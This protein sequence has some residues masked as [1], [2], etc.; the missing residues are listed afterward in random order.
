MAS[1]VMIDPYT[2]DSSPPHETESGGKKTWEELRRSVNETMKSLIMLGSSPPTSFTFRMV[3]EGAVVGGN[4]WLGRL[5]FLGTPEKAREN[6]LLYADLVEEEG[7]E[8]ELGKPVLAWTNLLDILQPSWSSGQLSRE[9]Q[10]ML[11]RKRM[12]SYGITSYDCAGA[13]GRFVF[14]ANSCLYM[15]EDRDLTC[16]LPSSIP[17]LPKLIETSCAG[18]RL[19]PKICPVCADI[20]AFVHNNDIWVTSLNTFQE[21]QLTFTQ[22]DPD[23]SRLE[24]NPLTAGVPSFVMSEEFD[25]YTGYWWQ[26]VADQSSAGE[27]QTLRVLYEEVDEG[28]VEILRIFA[29]SSQ[30]SD[31]VDEYRYPRAG[32]ANASSVLKI[33]EFQVNSFGPVVGSRQERHLVEPLTTHC[34]WAEYLVR[35]GWTPDGKYVYAQVLDRSQQHLRLLLIPVDCFVPVM[36]GD[37]DMLSLDLTTYPP[38]Q[39]IYEESNSIWINVHDILHFFPQTF[40]NEIS[41]VWASQKSGYRHLYHV[42]SSVSSSG[43]P[44]TLPEGEGTVPVPSCGQGQMLEEK[45]LTSGEWDVVG[46]QVWVDEKRAIV[47]FTGLKDTP[48]EMHLYAVSY[49][50]PS[51]IV[52]LTETGYSHIVTMNSDC[53]MFVTTYSNICSSPVSMVCKVQHDLQGRLSAPLSSLLQ[54]MPLCPSYQSPEMF[55][56]DSQSG[57]HHYGMFFRP[58]CYRPGVRYPTVLFVYGGPQVQLVS[59]SFKGLRFLRLHTLAAHGYAVV[60]VD[61]RGSCHR[62]LMFEG[63]VKDRLGTVEIVDQVEGLQY[64]AANYD[65]VDINRVAI[66]GWSYGGYLALMGLVQRPDVFKLAVAGAPVVSWKLYDTGYTERYMSLPHVNVLGYLRGSVLNYIKEFPDEENRLLIVHGLIDENVHFHH[67][68]KLV[69]ALVKACKPHRLQVYPNERHGIRSHES[70]EHYKTLLL[71]F[72][73]DNL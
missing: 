23:S 48:L 20:M 13:K 65:F 9:E 41:F 18:A 67:T 63:S 55:S 59:N 47:F 4:R 51:D 52:R 45:P 30:D 61:G 29:P 22:V 8:E 10:L 32:S 33:V 71:S 73:Q 53:S 49:A 24:D 39:C 60:V 7:S 6:S 2:V 31:G 34:P 40:E 28:K 1:E 57:Y 43:A 21:M 27:V 50:H 11:E 14:P 46:K 54:Q 3:P 37:I 25:R 36:D 58:T 26:P 15:C 19:D 64:V 70:N 72:L 56:Y 16:D 38:V 44:R 5:Y 69:T 42:T 12:G 62:G 35:A 68:S 66:H 17:V